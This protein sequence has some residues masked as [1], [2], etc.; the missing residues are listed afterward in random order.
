V[1]PVVID[2]SWR[3][4]CHNLMPVPF[5][6]RI[7]MHFG[8]P[9]PRDEADDG[10]VIFERARAEIEETLRRWRSEPVRPRA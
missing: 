3:L 6:V 10:S 7:R 8:N 5:G 9:I 4:L 2:G 1:L